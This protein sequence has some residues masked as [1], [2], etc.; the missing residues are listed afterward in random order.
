[1]EDNIKMLQDSGHYNAISRLQMEHQYC[2]KLNMK[3]Y[4]YEK[5]EYDTVVGPHQIFAMVVIKE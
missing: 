2:T 5:G 3:I 4:G 1:M